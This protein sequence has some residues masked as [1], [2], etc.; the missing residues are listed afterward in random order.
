MSRR[1]T[2][3]DPNRSTG[4]SVRLRGLLPDVVRD[5]VDLV[6]LVDATTG[7]RGR[8][9]VRHRETTLRRTRHLRE[10]GDHCP[11]RPV[12]VHREDVLEV[13][14]HDPALSRSARSIGSP[15]DTGVVAGMDDPGGERAPRWS[16]QQRP[17]RMRTGRPTGPASRSRP[18]RPRGRG[19]SRVGGVARAF[20]ILGRVSVPRAR[21]VRNGGASLI[22]R[23]RDDSIAWGED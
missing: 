7:S 5:D 23:T 22:R 21:V 15:V 8:R 18:A 16:P 10:P 11:L 20:Y 9:P 1:A 19:L 2:S 6:V 14:K 13:V 3:P 17:V 4:C 12:N